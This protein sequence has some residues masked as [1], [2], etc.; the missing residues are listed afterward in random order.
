MVY[1]FFYFYG[2]KL[3]KC[4]LQF[5]KQN[6]YVIYYNFRHTFVPYI[7]GRNVSYKAEY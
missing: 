3:R 5:K 7:F 6:Y 2:F 4:W 1:G